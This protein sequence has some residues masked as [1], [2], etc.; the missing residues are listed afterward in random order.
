MSLARSC[1]VIVIGGGVAGTA[2]ALGAANADAQ[3][4]LV[5]SAPFLGG[6]ATL[7]NVLTYCGLFTNYQKKQ[8]V[9]GVADQVLQ[10]RPRHWMRCLP[11]AHRCRNRGSQP[12]AHNMH[13][14]HPERFL[15]NAHLLLRKS[16]VES[17]R[18]SQ[19]EIPCA[20]IVLLRL[21]IKGEKTNHRQVTVAIVV[22]IE[23]SELLLAV[24]GVVSGIQIDGDAT[25]PTMQTLAM[26]FNDA[27]RQRFRHAQQFLTIRSIFKARQGRLRSQI[28]A[29]NGIP[30][31]QQ[32]VDRIRCQ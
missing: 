31:N 29:V 3:T 9:F 26:S 18:T 21:L 13:R 22:A 17:P 7:K 20:A 25:G 5:E 14:L 11:S 23:K 30:T 12:K 16:P 2:A 24:C 4:L 1:D 19:D 8:A 10:D 32:L 28:L 27:V 15:E 6:A